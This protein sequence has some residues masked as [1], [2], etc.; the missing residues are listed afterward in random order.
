MP[1]TLPQEVRLMDDKFNTTWYEI[2][3]EAID[4]VL[5]ATVIWA[6]LKEKKRFV[7]QTGS[8]LITRTI[9][10]GVGPTV[11][12]ISKGDLLPMGTVETT[13]QARWG[14][15]YLAVPVQRDMITDVENSGKF[16]IRDY[17]TKRLGEARDSLEQTLETDVVRTADTTEAA[18]KHPQS[19]LDIVP[20]YANATQGTY[21]GIA[22]P[23]A[24]T[25]IGAGNGVFAPSAGNTFWGPKY[26]Q[27]TSPTE[28]N[29]VSD[30]KV[31][32]NSIT[33]NQKA[34]NMIVSDQLTY[35]LYEEFAVDKSQIVKNDVGMLAD[36]GFETLEFKGA[37]WIWTPN[38]ANNELCMYDLM[39][40]EVVYRPNLWFEMTDWKSMPNQLERIAH[41]LTSLNIITDQPRRHGRLTGQSVA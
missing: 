23:S 20:P 41:I 4:N 7:G 21:G 31:L 17:V 38:F 28:V 30:M 14:F 5:L 6:M 33:N 13:T 26:K 19:L 35:E 27:M 1:V 40:I 32:W 15:R 18:H 36:L 39:S 9:R 34:P 37:P 8:D 25:Q 29:L 3:P 2:R 22:R 10:Y 16:K 24:Y 11:E 12:A